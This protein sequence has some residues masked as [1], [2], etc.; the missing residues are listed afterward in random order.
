MKPQ[1]Y[2]LILDF[3][4]FGKDATKCA[5]IDVS[6]L[7]FSWDRMLSSDPY[8]TED[9][10]LCKRFKLSVVDQVKNY[11]WEIDKG[12]VE[13]WETLGP[14]VRK[15][16][17]PKPDDLTVE[18]FTKEFMSYVASHIP[19]VDNWWSRSNTFDPIIFD[20]LFDSQGKLANIQEHLKFWKVRDTRTYIDAKLDFPKVNGFIPISNTDFWQRE[21]KEHD[22]SWDILAD[23]LRLQAIY[24]AENDLEQVTT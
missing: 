22:S 19:A 7:I 11:G 20:R 16:I 4:T 13:W 12:T 14:E 18:Q 5:V 23:V 6:A 24:R 15:H 9:I 8:G 1:K 17:K 3:E 21:F 2:D 10:Y